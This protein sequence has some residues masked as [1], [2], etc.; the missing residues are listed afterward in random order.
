MTLV[1]CV[2]IAQ[3]TSTRSY[4]CQLKPSTT[5]KTVHERAFGSVRIVGNGPDRCSR[6]ARSP[7]DAQRSTRGHADKSWE[8]ALACQKERAT[9]SPHAG[10]VGVRVPG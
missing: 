10:E 1:A 3:P 4:A 9:A 7:F 2:P 5:A 6:A 8:V